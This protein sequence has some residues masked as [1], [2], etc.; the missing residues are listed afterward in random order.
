MQF[1]VINLEQEVDRL[2]RELENCDLEFENKQSLMRILS[3]QLA[4]NATVNV[5]N[6][7]PADNENDEDAENAESSS[8]FLEGGKIYE[9]RNLGTSLKW[10]LQRLLSLYE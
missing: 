6:R 2:K 1:N 4:H 7:E 5:L 3:F 10:K 8:L 9:S